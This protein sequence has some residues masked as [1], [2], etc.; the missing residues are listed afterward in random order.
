MLYSTRL[1]F[2]NEQV[3]G[4]HLYNALQ[5]LRIVSS[6]VWTRRVINCG[7]LISAGRSWLFAPP[8]ESHFLLEA[9]FHEFFSTQSPRGDE[10][11][12]SE[13]DRGKAPSKAGTIGAV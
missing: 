11:G 12:G 3:V 4:L 6:G 7:S 8:F 2:A 10:S 1:A 9:S 13:Q 5:R